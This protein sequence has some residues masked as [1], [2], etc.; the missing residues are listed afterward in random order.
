[1][2]SPS[3]IDP[4]MLD[5]YRTKAAVSLVATGLRPELEYFAREI[6]A[7]KHQVQDLSEQVAKLQQTVIEQDERIAELEKKVS[8]KRKS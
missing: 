1:M 5:L 7:L 4:Q 8:K 6:L 3:Q 2:A